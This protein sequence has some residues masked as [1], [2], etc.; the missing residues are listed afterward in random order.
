MHAGPKGHRMFSERILD[1]WRKK[2]T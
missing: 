2:Y 1:D